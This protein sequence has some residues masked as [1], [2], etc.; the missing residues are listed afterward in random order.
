MDD[1]PQLAQRTQQFTADRGLDH[2]KSKTMLWDDYA[3]RPIID[4]R[5][6]W[7]VEKQAVDYDPSKTITRQLN[8]GKCVDN[9]L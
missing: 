1:E 9:I 7:L 3:I 5:K 2:K 8:V 4:L 6:L